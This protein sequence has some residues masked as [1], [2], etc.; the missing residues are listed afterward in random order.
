MGSEKMNALF[1]YTDKLNAP[2]E[3]FLL[4]ANAK[5]FPIQPHWHYFMEIIYMVEGTA[6]MNC[7]EQSFVA[8]QGDMVLFLPHQVHSIHASGCKRKF[9]GGIIFSG[10]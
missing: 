4:D 2:Y 5:N 8:E 10:R 3:C 9:Q 7:D 1:E 6:I